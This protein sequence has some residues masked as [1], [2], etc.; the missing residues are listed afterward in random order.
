MRKKKE[1]GG[2]RRKRKEQEA[3]WQ[4]ASVCCPIL[5]VCGTMLV[6]N[7]WFGVGDILKATP[8][9]TEALYETGSTT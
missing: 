8:V 5:G 1:K 7:G 6:A 3:N 4:D 2:N 9:R